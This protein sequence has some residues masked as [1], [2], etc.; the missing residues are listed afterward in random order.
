MGRVNPLSVLVLILSCAA[1][2]LGAQV[3]FDVN[4]TTGGSGV[5]ANSV[6]SWNTTANWTTRA[7]GA[8]AG[9]PVRAWNN[10]TD[11]SANF[12]AGTDATGS[13]LVTIGSTIN[14]T[15]ITV[16]EGTPNFKVNTG[17]TWNI[18]QA[19]QLTGYLTLNGGTLALGGTGTGTAGRYSFG[20]LYVQTSSTLDF[21]SLVGGTE[22]FFSAVYIAAGQTLSISNWA[23]ASDLF[24]TGAVFV[25]GTYSESGATPSVSSFT[26][27][28]GS[29]NTYLGSY[30]TINGVQAQWNGSTIQTFTPI[31]EPST[32]GAIMAAGCAGLIGWRRR[33]SRREAATKA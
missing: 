25:G 1:I 10:A 29:T 26:T 18:A 13:Y 32:Y 5:T 11:T 31:P 16:G 9:S 7:A 19:E 22:I 8:N 28:T 3:Y 33:R 15:T 24:K 17:G 21:G 12:S 6:R 14:V 30:A 2:D 27:I 20:N 4:G 23:A